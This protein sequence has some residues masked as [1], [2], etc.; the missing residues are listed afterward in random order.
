MELGKALI[1]SM[2]VKSST[3][4]HLKSGFPRGPTYFATEERER[5]RPCKPSRLGCTGICITANQH[6]ARCEVEVHIKGRVH[7][8][9]G[10]RAAHRMYIL[11]AVVFAECVICW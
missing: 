3:Q 10:R 2:V 9:L 1:S 11:I 6:V 8:G 4:D 5:S 7:L